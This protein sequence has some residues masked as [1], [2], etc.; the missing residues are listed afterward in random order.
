MVIASGRLGTSNDGLVGSRA[1]IYVRV[2]TQ[3]QEDGA[4]LEVQLETCRKYCEAHGL[5]IVGEFRDVQTGLDPDRPQY[6]QAKELARAKGFDQLVVWRYDR[7]GRDDYEYAGMLKD[8]AK[9]GIQLVSSSGESPDPSYQKIAGLLAWDESRRISLR[10]TGSKMKR[11]ENGYWSSKPPFGYITERQPEGGSILVP[12]QGEAE[13]VVEIFERYATGKYSLREIQR[14]L[15]ASLPLKQKSR[16]GINQILQ[17]RVYLGEVPYGAYVDSEFHA[18]PSAVE[19]RPG[20]HKALVTAEVYDRVQQMLQG[21]K[22]SYGKGSKGVPGP[23]RGGPNARYLFTG[24]IYCGVCASRYIG[25]P[26]GRNK[27]PRY[28]CGRKH[29]GVGCA[30]HTIYETRLRGVVIT[31]LERFIESVQ[32][33]DFRAAVRAELVR[34]EEDSKSADVAIKLAAGE[35]L[36]RLEARLTRL[37]D[38]Y[39]DGEIA[40]E[41]YRARRDDLMGQI[42]ELKGQLSARP[43]VVLPDL[44]AFFAM[45]DALAGEPPNDEEWR[46][47]IV[48]AVDRIVI[49]GH[50][51]R[52]VWKDAFVPLLES[53]NGS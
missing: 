52:V 13:L 19:W 5:E 34:Q 35:S 46:D 8:F 14:W 44:D 6:Q 12:K 48:G 9:L 32:R 16:R 7:S 3:R 23:S 15:N 30:S 27:W 11:F 39:L 1:A 20:K 37:E 4:S 40:K 43:Q 24:L 53:V 17:S 45:A 47:I 21:N 51:I 33:Q 26:P 10:V 38:A 36:A 31:P 25:S 22:R 50:D 42:E 49:E 41:R 2:S 28:M 29:T 18:K